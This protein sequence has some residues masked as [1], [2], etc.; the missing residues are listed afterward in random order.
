[1]D[2]LKLR[3]CPFCK[4][5]N[6]KSK[7][8]KYQSGC[9]ACLSCGM[10]GPSANSYEEAVEL[11][12]TRPTESALLDETEEKLLAE[13]ERLNCPVCGGSGTEPDLAEGVGR[14]RNRLKA[15]GCYIAALEARASLSDDVMDQVFAITD[16]R[17][18]ANYGGIVK[19]AK[20][21]WKGTK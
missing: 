11:W 14:L 2:E 1:M 17:Q 13:S 19:E 10:L 4:E 21:E 18:W 6:Q 9:I 15:A 7:S 5:G 16:A 3:D 12:N 20:A 8:L